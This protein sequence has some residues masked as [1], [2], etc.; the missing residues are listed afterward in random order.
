MRERLR[1]VG[2][3]VDRAGSA[4]AADVTTTVWCPG[5]RRND[6]ASGPPIDRHRD[7]AVVGAVNSPVVPNGSSTSTTTVSPSRRQPIA[8]RP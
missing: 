6:G 7:A 8:A 2:E 1:G 3:G 4:T 5:S